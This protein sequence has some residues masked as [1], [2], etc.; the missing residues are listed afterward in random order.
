MS[1]LSVFFLKKLF[2]VISSNLYYAS[3]VEQLADP[4]V[5]KQTER[6]PSEGGLEII[7]AENSKKVIRGSAF[8]LLIYARNA[9]RI[10]GDY[11]VTVN[12]A[13]KGADV[14]IN[15]G[16]YPISSTKD[17]PKNEKISIGPVMVFVP[18]TIPLGVYTVEVGLLRDNQIEP[19]AKYSNNTIEV[20]SYSNPVSPPSF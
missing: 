10:Y 16:E 18:A 13:Q 3:S 8:E 20:V 6:A 9:Q 2:S 1:F 19:K 11:K 5:Q 17:W 14:N 12:L 7:C 15:S 4:V